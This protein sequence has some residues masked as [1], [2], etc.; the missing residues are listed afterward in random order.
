MRSV[1]SYGACFHWLTPDPQAQISPRYEFGFGLSYTTFKYSNLQV[2]TIRQSD[3][4][5]A[6]LEAKWAAGKA[7][8]LEV[9]SSAAIWLHRPVVQ[10]EFDVKNAGKVTGGEVSP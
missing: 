6:D 2:S 7:A 9:G 5:F 3:R 8:P 1:D 10:V 4:T